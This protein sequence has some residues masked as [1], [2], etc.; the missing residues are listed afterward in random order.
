M[1][2]LWSTLWLCGCAA[3]RFASE[4]EVG[5]KPE[6][7]VSHHFF[8]SFLS[9]SFCT[10]PSSSQNTPPSLSR[11]IILII[12]I[13]FSLAIGIL[14]YIDN[15]AHIGGFLMG[16]VSGVIC[17]PSITFGPWDLR[18]K[19]IL[20]G[21]CIPLWLVMFGGVFFMLFKGVDLSSCTDCL[22]IDCVPF[23]PGWCTPA[24]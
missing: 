9:S 1:W 13:I 20:I 19:R 16:I 18:R 3:D 7:T 10:N 24:N 15:F 17:V 21:I 4:L 22:Y 12:V 23:A 5:P 6:E 2:V 14:P 11:L 8:F